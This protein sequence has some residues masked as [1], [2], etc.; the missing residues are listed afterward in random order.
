MSRPKSIC[1]DSGGGSLL[2]SI[3]A[4]WDA[5]AT[6]AASSPLAAK[7]HWRR[8]W[9]RH[10]RLFAFIT[11]HVSRVTHHASRIT[12]IPQPHVHVRTVHRRVASRR[13]AGAHPEIRGVVFLADIDMP[14]S[15][16][17][18]LDLRMASRSEERRV[19]K[20]CRS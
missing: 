11:H 20:E 18:A 4:A 3:S 9:S 2:S 16:A 14:G 1:T 19:G 15:H 13:P 8:P 5:S 12:L 6:Q 17:R 10:A 7:T